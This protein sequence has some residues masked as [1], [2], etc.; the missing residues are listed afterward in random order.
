[1]HSGRFQKIAK[2]TTNIAH[3]G[4]NRFAQL[5]FPLPPIAEQARIVAEVERRLSVVD[6]L[7]AVVF[8]NLRRAIRLRQS[9]LQRAFSGAEAPSRA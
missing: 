2:W 4:A 3:L 1:M 6:Q 8:A 5:A 9:V 7:D